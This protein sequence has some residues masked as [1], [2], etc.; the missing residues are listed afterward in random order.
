MLSYHPWEMHIPNN[1]SAAFTDTQVIYT[2]MVDIQMIQGDTE[3]V[4]VSLTAYK[5]CYQWSPTCL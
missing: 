5:S 3:V 4:P 2:N 1:G